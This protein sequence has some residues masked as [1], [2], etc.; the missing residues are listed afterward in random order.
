MV[1]HGHESE[2]KIMIWVTIGTLILHLMIE[3]DEVP[4]NVCIR[5]GGWS[6]CIDIMR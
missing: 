4:V 6:I 5:I 1:S 2:S 3:A